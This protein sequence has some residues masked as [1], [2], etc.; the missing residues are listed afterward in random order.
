MLAR[1][2]VSDVFARSGAKP[3]MMRLSPVANHRFTDS[4]PDAMKFPDDRLTAWGESYSIDSK[5]TVVR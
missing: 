3:E 4:W 5:A 1:N 2:E